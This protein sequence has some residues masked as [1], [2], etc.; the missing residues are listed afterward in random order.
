MCPLLLIWRYEL[1]DT[2][3]R[4]T[5]ELAK[6]EVSFL[7]SEKREN[8]GRIKIRIKR[9]RQII[10]PLCFWSVRFFLFFFFWLYII[11]KDENNVT[12]WGS[13]YDWYKVKRQ[14][15]I[16][17]RTIGRSIRFDSIRSMANPWAGTSKEGFTVF[18]DERRGT[19]RPSGSYV[20]YKLQRA[21]WFLFVSHVFRKKKEKIK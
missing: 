6:D 12:S 1:K 8:G 21:A 10:W 7:R 13:I 20:W 14:T 4:D 18:G 17:D 3:L 9:Q 15:F 16:F 19:D 11:Y 2:K 5:R